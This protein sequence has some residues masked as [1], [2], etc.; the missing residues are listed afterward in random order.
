MPYLVF[1]KFIRKFIFCHI[2]LIHQAYSNYKCFLSIPTSFALFFNSLSPQQILIKNTM[3]QE[4]LNNLA[5]LY[6]EK[7]F[8]INFNKII[9]QYI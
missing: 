8:K 4:R 3:D 9:D 2:F 7:T 1:C 5:I 6:I